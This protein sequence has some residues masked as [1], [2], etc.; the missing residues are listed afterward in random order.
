MK[1]W[2]YL[3]N[4]RLITVRAATQAEAA[5]KAKRLLVCPSRG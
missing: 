2:Y 3:I 4:S 1:K 5:R